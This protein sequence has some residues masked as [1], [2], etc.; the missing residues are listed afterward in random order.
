MRRRLAVLLACAALLGGL[1]AR[2]AGAAA[3][4]PGCAAPTVTPQVVVGRV[5]CQRL[6]SAALGGT[7]AFSYYVPPRCAAAACPVLYLLHGFGGDYTSMLGTADR[8]SAWVA[9]LS[10][11]PPVP[12]ERDPAPWDEADPVGWV[13][14]RPL[15]LVLVAPDG[16][17]VPGGYGPAP[18]L[19]GFWTDWNPRYARGGD[20]QAYATPAPRF[21][22]AL[23]RELVPYVEANLPVLR[24]RDSRG[25]TGTS[26]GGYG[27]YA[28]GLT[29]PDEW[30]SLGAVSGIMNLLLL[31]GLDPAPQV[32]S[33]VAGQPPTPLPYAAL[34]GVA[35]ATP[36]SA[37]PGPARNLAA[38]FLAFGDPVADQA[39]YRAR[40]PRDLAL[41]GRARGRG[42]RP[43]VPIRGFSND[44]VP[45]R[46][47]DV[48]DP[49]SYAVAQAFEGAVLASNAEL[50]ASFARLGVPNDYALHPG[51]HSDP[52]WNPW[53]RGQLLAQ[54]ARLRHADGTGDP[55]PWAAEFSYRSAARSFQ[56]WGWQLRV[57]RPNIEFLE[58]DAVSCSGF[59]LRGTGVVRVTVPARC[60]TGGPGGGRVVTVELGPSAPTD[61]PAGADAA[62][63]YGRTVH[64]ALSPRGR[65]AP[66]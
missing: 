51:I 12:P 1:S 59:T 53:L 40:M 39:Y 31:P 37:Y 48:A 64:V 49:A 41:N 26:L 50:E 13:P 33:P 22:E 32:R 11:R 10:R 45:R 7:T 55:P 24:G 25:L 42:G 65:G 14:A 47:A 52:Y 35:P 17:T 62:P 8:P 61:A 21:V 18:Y 63:A 27:A 4:F 46:A 58:L 38:V 20:R 19:E 16:R 66:R 29:Y 3:A 5:A 9:A 56:V 15:D 6:P 28:I 44:A 30:A 60:R 54:D 43:A 57:D 2:P 36:P 23:R 34:P